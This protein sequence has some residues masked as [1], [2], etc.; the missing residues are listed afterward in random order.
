MYKNILIATDGS[1]LAAKAVDEG[2]ALAKEVG[3]TVTAV[4]VMEPFPWGSMGMDFGAS[5]SPQLLTDFEVSSEQISK[6]ILS[7]VAKRAQDASVKY[8]TVHIRD[9]PPF[10][11]IIETA[12]SKKCDLIVMASHGRKGIAA[13]VLGSQ[14]VKVLTHSE[15]PVLVCR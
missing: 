2:I 9:R 15:I 5:V 7:S 1:T 12:K 6:E 13:V 10:T 8:E 11:G 3:A 14:T 4:Y